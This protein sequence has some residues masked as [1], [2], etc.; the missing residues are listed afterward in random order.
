MSNSKVTI[1]TRTDVINQKSAQRFFDFLKDRSEDVYAEHPSPLHDSITDQMGDHI[2]TTNDFPKGMKILD[3]GCGQGPFLEK[4]KKLGYKAVGVT[5]SQEDVDICNQKG[6]EVY[7]MDQSFLN[8][9]DGEF[10]FIWARH[11]LEHSLMPYFTLSEF[12]RV[13]SPDGKLYIE[14]PA[15]EAFCY[16]EKN[17]NHYSI[18]GKTMWLALFEKVGFEIIDDKNLEITD[19]KNEEVYY[20][21]LLK[22]VLSGNEKKEN[23]KIVLA[24]SSG[25]NFGWGV[26]SKYL[27][28]EVSKLTET[29][30]WDFS[31]EDGSERKVDGKVVHAITGLEFES[32]SK[33]RG[34][35]NYGYTFFENELIPQS[36][37]NSKKYDLILGGSTWCTEKMKAAGINNVDTLIQGIDPGIFYPIEK[38]KTN[39]LFIIFSG[40]KFE[41]RKGQDLVLKAIKILQKKYNDIILL[42]AWYN[43]WPESMKLMGRSQHVD[44]DIKGN[45][46]IELME[47]VYQLNGID[48]NRIMTH[49][50][51]PND[52]LREIYGITDLALFPNRCEGGTNLVMM[53]YMACGKPVIASYNSG[54]KDVLTKKNS[55]MLEDMRDSRI[56]NN[57][58][59]LW[60]DWT[61]PSLD[62]IVEKIEWAYQNRSQLKQIGKNAGEF[63]KKYTWEESAK[64]LLRIIS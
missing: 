20:S 34:S 45:N 33:I 21:F 47:Y 19:G 39:D 42:N 11:V 4:V 59:S 55:I 8:F 46:W 31:M 43:M 7:K 54:H 37:E 40:G 12:R 9:E 5:L 36:L 28:Q 38:E 22:K 53:E 30:I 56:Y 13:L 16:H 3:V 6:F 57:D 25:E 60:A 10:D 14:V 61:E 58:N 63:M 15:P 17:P 62:E 18:L 49:E 23:K 44:F 48:K 1:D 27:K 26:C 52:K 51:I 64:S 29:E 41:Y 35:E 2:F 24:L 32:I 50:I